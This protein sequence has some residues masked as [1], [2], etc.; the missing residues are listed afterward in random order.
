M[1]PQLRATVMM[2]LHQRHTEM[3]KMLDVANNYFWWPHLNG[4]IQLKS[5]S[6]CKECI[7]SG[8]NLKSI[9]P[10]GDFTKLNLLEETNQELQLHFLGAYKNLISCIDRLSKFPSIQ[11]TTRNTAAVTRE[12]FKNHNALHAVS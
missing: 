7:K 8:E 2:R 12:L 5:N 3:F 11:T 4:Q 6:T 1:L 10:E 9:F